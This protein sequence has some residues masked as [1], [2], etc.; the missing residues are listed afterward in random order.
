[1]RHLTTQKHLR[2][3]AKP[4][5]QQSQNIHNIQPTQIR[6]CSTVHMDNVTTNYSEANSENVCCETASEEYMDDTQNDKKEEDIPYADKLLHNFRKEVDTFVAMIR[7]IDAQKQ[8]DNDAKSKYE[9]AYLHK[10]RTASID[11]NELRDFGDEIE[12]LNDDELLQLIKYN[13]DFSIAYENAK[14][15]NPNIPQ[16][17]NVKYDASTKKMQIRHKNAWCEMEP[18]LFIDII[19][20]N[21]ITELYIRI[22]RIKKM[23]G[24]DNKPKMIYVVVDKQ[25]PSDIRVHIDPE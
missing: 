15:Y 12:A 20:R 5:P 11:D 10:N 4:L 22:Q 3:F 18:S 7:K 8:F 1:M 23:I 6:N 17:Y 24:F 21:M 16:N 25:N 14:Y 2:N 13:K 19:Y 9:N